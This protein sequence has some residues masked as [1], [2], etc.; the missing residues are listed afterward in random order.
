[1]ARNRHTISCLHVCVCV[2]VCTYM[3]ICG[4]MLVN[5]LSG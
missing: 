3:Y 2:C 5:V 4:V 1:M